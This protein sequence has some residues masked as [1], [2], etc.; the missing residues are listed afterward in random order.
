MMNTRKQILLSLAIVGLAASSVAIYS[1]VAPSGDATGGS[2]GHNHGAVAGDEA[3][4]PVHVDSAMARRIGVTYATAASRPLDRAVSTV[5]IVTYDETRLFNVNPKIE[6]WVERLYVDFTGAPIRKGQPLMEIYSP[7]LVSAQEELIL[8]R[9]LVDQASA[10]KSER[11]AANA[12]DLL[13]SARQRLSYWDIPE[14]EIEQIEHALV[15]RK[16]LTFRAGAGGIVVEKNVVEGSRIMPGMDLYKIADLSRVWINGELFEKDISL[17]R[18]GQ[19][20][21]V[22]FDAYPGEDFHGVVTYVYPSVSLEA[23]TGQV[24]LELSNPGLKLMPGMYAQVE[25]RSTSPR[26]ALLIPRSAVLVTGERSLVFVRESDGMLTP[27]EVHAGLVAGS[28]IEILSGL[29]AGEV[30]V[31]SANFLIDAESNLG[32]SAGAMAGMD[33]GSP[34]GRQGNDVPAVPAP[35]ALSTDTSAQTGHQH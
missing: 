18:Q 13:S 2:G 27:R 31:T 17:V 14:E 16:T 20:A 7:M 26:E 22:T 4:S 1:A 9:R 35:A 3:L 34:A 6:G 30:V 32:A 8:A 25:I 29:T 23:R 33:M 12:R 15:P 21:E 19:R 5:G 24:R 28:D 11:A 10:G